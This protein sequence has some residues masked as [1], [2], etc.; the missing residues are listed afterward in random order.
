[1]LFVFVVH[2]GRLPSALPSAFCEHL[3]VL[4]LFFMLQ[5]LEQ[6]FLFYLFE[7]LFV[8]S[9]PRLLTGL[10]PDVVDVSWLMLR[11][12]HL[13]HVF[14][15]LDDAELLLGLPLDIAAFSRLLRLMIALDLLAGAPE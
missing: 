13:L 1:M 9:S 2:E 12:C 6:H 14:F 8:I 5:H 4:D 10:R 3:I 15:F 11:P 7:L